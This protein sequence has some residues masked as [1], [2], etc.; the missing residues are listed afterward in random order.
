MSIRE[1]EEMSGTKMTK[2]QMVAY[3]HMKLEEVQD[4]KDTIKRGINYP[5]DVEENLCLLSCKI[6]AMYH[7]VRHYVHYREE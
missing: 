3:L 6:D 1:L 4:A 5:E 2:D 7:K